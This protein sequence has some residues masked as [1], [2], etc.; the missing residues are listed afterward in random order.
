MLLPRQLQVQY[1]DKA[2]DSYLPVAY[3]DGAARP[4]R[5]GWRANA[6]TSSTSPSRP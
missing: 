2:S 4:S 6:T 5:P 3:T 1:Y